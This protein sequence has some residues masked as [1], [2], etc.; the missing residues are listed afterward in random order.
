MI[1]IFAKPA[2]LNTS[3]N[4]HFISKEKS[5]KGYG[6]LQRVSSMIRGDQIA[7][8]I[9]ARF[10]PKEITP[11]STCIYV[12]PYVKSGDDFS[13]A[14]SNSY[15]DIVDGWGLIP[16][17]E[18]HPE[19]GAIACSAQDY[20]KL[21]FLPNKKVFI[22]Q[23]HCNYDRE[24]RTKKGIKTVGIIGTKNAFDW[25][26]PRVEIG[27]EERGI[28]LI[29]YSKFFSRQDVIDFYKQIDVQMVWRPYRM[30]LSNPLKI[31][32]AASFGIPTIAYEESV[33]HEVTGCYL[34]VQDPQQ[35]LDALDRLIKSEELYESL[36]HK[37]L[38]TS[39][40]YHIENIAKLYKELES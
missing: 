33:F 37:C 15:I 19:V 21:S 4:G 8:Y 2:F 17:L 35:W 23:H 27:L 16:L 3:P 40:T 14:T 24:K 22:P 36:S 20:D 26:P 25:I 28:E 29:K 13:F 9:G 31:V 12:K 32:N 18:K 7:D 39:D 38:V 34:P 10:N 5:Y 6:H 30:R 11:E 1:N